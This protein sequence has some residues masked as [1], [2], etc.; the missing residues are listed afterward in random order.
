MNSPL[1]GTLMFKKISILFIIGLFTNSFS[2]LSDAPPSADGMEPLIPRIEPMAHTSSNPNLYVSAENPLFKNYFAGPQVIEVIVVDPDINR[3][4][5]AYGEPVVTVNG[6]RLR[7]AQ[8]TDGSWH[9]FFADVNRSEEHTS[10][11]Q[12]PKDLVC[13]LL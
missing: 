1:S 10:E 5:Q 9:A 12:S 11:L 4:D 13:R 7:M 6:K 3:L 8:T 2:V